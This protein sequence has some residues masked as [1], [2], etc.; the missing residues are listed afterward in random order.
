MLCF[1]FSYVDHSDHVLNAWMSI[2]VH[3]MLF[4]SFDQGK[5]DI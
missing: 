5:V 2:P 4:F 3:A 1:H